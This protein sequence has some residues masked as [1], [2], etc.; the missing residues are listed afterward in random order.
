MTF[1]YSTKAKMM[2][3]CFACVPNDDINIMLYTVASCIKKVNV[4]EHLQYKLHVT[5]GA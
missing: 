4:M 2:H 1:N 3:I 5:R